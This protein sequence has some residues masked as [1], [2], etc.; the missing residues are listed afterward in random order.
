MGG[1][2]EGRVALITGGATGI[3]A[4]SARRLAAEGAAV[5]VTDLPSQRELA[6]GVVA[7]IA[8]A[9]GRAAFAPLDVRDGAQV[10]DAFALATDRF[11]LPDAIVTAAG[12]DSH[13]DHGFSGN[14][15]YDLPDDAMRFVLDVNLTGTYLVLRGAAQRLVAAGRPGTL[16]TLASAAAKKPKGG[17]Y[18]VSKAAVWMLT[19]VLADELGPHGIRVNSIGP[20]YID[21]PMLARRS[22]LTT[23]DGGPA[24]PEAWYERRASSVPLRRLGTPDEVASIVLFLSS[25]ESSY[26]TG[27]ILHPDGGLVSNEGGG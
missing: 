2:M 4:A 26:V 5:L 6:D 27:S 12:V 9:G 19:R 10:E 25:D 20:G 22:T 3:G 18:A 24:D 11:G 17:A 15:L 13:P 8:A 23:A 21:T 16:V 14:V 7:G 1:L